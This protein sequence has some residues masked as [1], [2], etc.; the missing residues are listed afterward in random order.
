[1]LGP[2]ENTGPRAQSALPKPKT[3]SDQKLFE[4]CREFESVMLGMVFKQMHAAK[5][6]ADP[7]EQSHAFKTFRDMQADETAKGMA[8]AGG[9]GLADS[10]YRQLYA[11]QAQQAQPRP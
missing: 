10:L 1:M 4:A 8:K 7:L 11:M 9:I 3:A 5:L 2:I 6:N